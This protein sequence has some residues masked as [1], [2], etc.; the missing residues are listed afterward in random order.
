M[1]AETLDRLLMDR[2]L[3][4]LA[5]D[6]TE[7]LDDLCARD[8]QAAARAREFAAAA[9]AARTVLGRAARETPENLPE[10]PALR[11]TQATRGQRRRL[12]LQRL[13]GIAAVLVLGFG[14]G[15]VVYRSSAPE[16]VVSVP[17]GED[18]PEV[19]ARGNDVRDEPA[20][21]SAGFWSLERVAAARQTPGPRS[22]GPRLI[23][24]SPVA[25]PRLGGVR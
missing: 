6:M 12:A 19:Q 14:L 4:A 17:A 10:Y 23:W 22:D 9:D 2:A 15:A 13:S 1:N 3:G 21:R 24:D 25:M 20:E 11:V 8:P 16:R 5:P 7:L 18:R